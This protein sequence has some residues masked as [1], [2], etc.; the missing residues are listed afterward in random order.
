MSDAP[1]KWTKIDIRAC[2]SQLDAFW[3]ARRGPGSLAPS[4]HLEAEHT[5]AVLAN[6]TNRKEAVLAGL[7]SMRDLHSRRYREYC[8]TIGNQLVRFTEYGKPDELIDRFI[9][10]ARETDKDQRAYEALVLRVHNE[11]LPPEVLAYDPTL[12]PKR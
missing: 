1:K 6:A 7:R 9:K 5:R 2:C 11:G 12:P 4:V 3:L 10:L 8:E